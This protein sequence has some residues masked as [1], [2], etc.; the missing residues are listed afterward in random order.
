MET[1]SQS[2]DNGAGADHQTTGEQSPALKIHPVAEIFPP[3][4][5]ED[6]NLLVEDIRKKWS[7]RTNPSA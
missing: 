1:T 6:F 7:S 4:T 2:P 3:L 5:G